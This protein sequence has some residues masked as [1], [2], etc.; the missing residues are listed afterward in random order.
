MIVTVAVNSTTALV[1]LKGLKSYSGKEKTFTRILLL[2]YFR[3]KRALKL[4][5]DVIQK[6]SGLRAV[7]KRYL[8]IDLTI[9]QL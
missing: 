3:L 8:N 9:V 2:T 6:C 7:I 5:K 4:C 1:Y